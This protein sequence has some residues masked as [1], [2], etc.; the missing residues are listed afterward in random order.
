MSVCDSDYAERNCKRVDV[1]RS[2]H[3]GLHATAPHYTTLYAQM[4][5]E[6]I[7]NTSHKPKAGLHYGPA[8]ESN[9]SINIK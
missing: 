4:P 8:R 2:K 9:S 7:P 1:A 3:E 6:L 5:N